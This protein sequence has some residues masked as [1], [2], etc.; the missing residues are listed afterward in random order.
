MQ[1]CLKC[2]AAE[3][4]S[5]CS[6]YGSQDARCPLYKAWLRKKKSAYDVKMALPLEKHKEKLNDVEVSPADIELGIVKLIKNLKRS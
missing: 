1:T 3:P 5:A 4:D 6:I 2:A